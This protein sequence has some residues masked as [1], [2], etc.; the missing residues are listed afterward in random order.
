MTPESQVAEPMHPQ[1]RIIRVDT[2]AARL[3]N[4]RRQWDA[5]WAIYDG[6]TSELSALEDYLR[7]A[8]PTYNKDEII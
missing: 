1:L 2:I 3:R 8:R 4:V 5:L 7:G 6:G